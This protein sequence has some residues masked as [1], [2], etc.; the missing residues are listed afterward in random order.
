MAIAFWIWTDRND[1][2]D[3]GIEYFDPAGWERVAGGIG[4]G[5]GGQGHL[6]DEM[7]SMSWKHRR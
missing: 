7:C 5:Q 6:S 4:Y 1:K 2:R 3:R